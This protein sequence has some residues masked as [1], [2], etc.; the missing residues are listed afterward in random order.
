MGMTTT[1]QSQTT[2]PAAERYRVAMKEAVDLSYERKITIGTTRYFA[3]IQ[4]QC[5]ISAIERAI[6]DERMVIASDS[7]V[8]GFRDGR[9]YEDAK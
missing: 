2:R 4:D 9:R 3:E 1:D 6:A 5:I 8:R 7:Y